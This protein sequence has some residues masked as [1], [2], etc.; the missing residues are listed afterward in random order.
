MTSRQ[1]IFCPYCGSR[2]ESRHIDGMK[3]RYCSNCG[4]VIYENPIPAVSLV[5]IEQGK[6]LLVK[7]AVEP[8]KGEWCLP[9]GFLEITESPEQAVVR[10][11]MEETGLKAIHFE[12]I[13]LTSQD[14]ECYKNVLLIGYNIVS[15]KGQELQAD[16]D[17]EE[18]KFFSRGA[19]PQLAFEGH[20][21]FLN[22]ILMQRKE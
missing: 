6:V 9:G 13:G 4:K 2:L 1:K 5:L 7:R 21:L 8:Q 17:A 12:L 16:D 19:I 11:L 20:E 15:F 14:S 3:R 18:A 10:E 22:E